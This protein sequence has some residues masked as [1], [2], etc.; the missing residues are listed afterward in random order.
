M[1][2][3]IDPTTETYG[4]HIIYLNSLLK[5][6]GTCALQLVVDT[7]RVKPNFLSVFKYFWR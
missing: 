4:H 1:I 3:L 6:E 7:K 5:I 2:Y